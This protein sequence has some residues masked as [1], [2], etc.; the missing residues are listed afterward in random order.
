VV[1]PA[2]STNNAIVRWDGLN[3][4]LI[5]NSGVIID[6]TNNIT[7]A[8]S[9]YAGFFAIS[10]GAATTGGLRLPHGAGVHSR[11]YSGSGNLSLINAIGVGN[12][13][14]VG[15][16]N[17][18]T[19]NIHSSG[20]VS[21]VI[22]GTTRITVSP[23]EVNI[24]LNEMTLPIPIGTAGRSTFFN[25]NYGGS[26]LGIIGSSFRNTLGFTYITTI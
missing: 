22:G 9:V 4:K 8:A 5:K 2:L 13:I 26:C 15:D 23:M 7:G 24:T 3:G 6:N 11:N 12:F 20:S 1:G 21:M 17:S 10:S 25:Y 18:V 14:R 16:D 19:T